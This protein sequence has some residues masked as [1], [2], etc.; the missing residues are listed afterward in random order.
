M[1]LLVVYQVVL[2]REAW[3]GNVVH[4]NSLELIEFDR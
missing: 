2:L 3:T 4:I 1:Q